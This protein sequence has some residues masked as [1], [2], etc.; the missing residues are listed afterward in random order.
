M[1]S[2]EDPRPARA[3]SNLTFGSILVLVAI[4]FIAIGFERFGAVIFGVIGLLQVI[5]GA[6]FYW[7][8]RD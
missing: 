5:I 1:N 4:V 3:R 6:L 2:P 8:Q 7:S